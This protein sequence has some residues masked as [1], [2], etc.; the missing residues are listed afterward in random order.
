M[1]LSRPKFFFIWL[2]KKINNL[3]VYGNS[4]IQQRKKT[5]RI[6]AFRFFS[7]THF[8]SKCWLRMRVRVWIKRTFYRSLFRCTFWCRVT[9]EASKQGSKLECTVVNLRIP[10]NSQQMKLPWKSQNCKKNENSLKILKL[11]KK[12]KISNL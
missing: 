3:V 8:A 12:M 10:Q 7:K 11:Q 6:F 2:P 5:F 4:D 9:V 1:A